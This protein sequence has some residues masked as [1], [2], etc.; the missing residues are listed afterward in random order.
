MAVTE[1]VTEATRLP[2]IQFP[3]FTAKLITDV[4]DALVSANLKQT[5]SYIELV[6]AIGKGVSTYIND[7]KDD[8]SGEELLHFLAKVVPP[9]DDDEENNGTKIIE[10]GTITEVEADNLKEALRKTPTEVISAE[11]VPNAV[12]GT[13]TLTPDAFEA[14]LTAAAERIASNKYY[15]LEKMVQ[16]GIL[17]LVVEN[18]L[19]ETRLT[20]STHGSSFYQEKSNSYTR[21]PFRR[22]K[23]TKT[24]GIVALF[25]RS[26][27]ATNR[28]S[29]RISTA[30]KINQDRTGS[31][32]NIF[33]RVQLNFKTDYLPLNQ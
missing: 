30:E 20:F 21:R 25:G 32:V 28:T 8:I 19:I 2:D 13:V 33:G 5:E 26:A 15:L 11:T 18:G 14:I 3:E 22:R 4:F 17:R 31:S 12:D 16:Q 24:S 7:T 6:S 23:R 29:L 1:A 27:S 9:T 10:G